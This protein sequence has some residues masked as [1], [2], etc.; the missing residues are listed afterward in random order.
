RSKECMLFLCEGLSASSFVIKGTGTKRDVYGVFPLKGKPLNVTKSSSDKV[1]ENTEIQSLRKIIGLKS[2][3]DYSQDENLDTLRYGSVCLAC[4]ADVDGIHIRFLLHNLFMEH[5]KTLLKRGFVKVLLTPIIKAVHGK[6]AKKFYSE[7]AFQQWLQEDENNKNWKTYH[8]K[9]L[10]TSED[11][12]I[13]E[14]FNNPNIVV[15]D[16][17]EKA[18]DYFKIAFEKYME[19][20]RKKWILNY[21]PNVNDTQN[22]EGSLS[23]GINNELILYSVYSVKTKLPS[24]FDGLKVC[25]RKILYGAMKKGRK[26]FI[27]V[28]QLASYVA[29]LTS[30]HHG[31][32]SLSD[33]IINMGQDFIGSNNVPLLEK[34]GQFGSRKELGKDAGSGRYIYTRV[35]SIVQYLFRQ[36]DEV[37]LEQVVDENDVV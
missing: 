11:E 9:G 2:N 32:G 20:L 4:D 31:E 14:E 26:E 16:Y 33:A 34:K 23:Y 24:L 8:M 37:L 22:K 18:E 35:S 1:N 13:S 30:Y 21:D 28:D 10:A 25:Q 7:K 17:D 12:D 19:D 27:K 29:E 5:Y 36:E 15:Y 6:Q 3:V